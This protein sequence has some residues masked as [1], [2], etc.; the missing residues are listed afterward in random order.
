MG[1]LN[2]KEGFSHTFIRYNDVYGIED[3]RYYSNGY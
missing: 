1:G 3:R 2:G